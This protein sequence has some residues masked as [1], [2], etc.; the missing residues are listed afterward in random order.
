MTHNCCGVQT[1]P[2]LND[3]L[4]S[5]FSSYK[6]GH[7][8]YLIPILQDTQAAFSYLSRDNLLHI[9]NHVGIPLSK[10]YGVATFYNQFRLSAPGQHTILVCRGTACHVRGSDV[11]LRAFESELSI[12][13]GQTTR[14]GLITLDVV[15]CLGSCSIAPVITLDGKFHGRL[16]TRDCSRI[17]ESIGKE[18]VK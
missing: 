15:A 6:A 14:N 2:P 5:I 8:E 13:A 12:K 10:V 7:R 18:A 9:A 4:T 11:I 3:E 17:L 16:T 1:T